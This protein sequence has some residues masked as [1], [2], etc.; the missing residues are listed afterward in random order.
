MALS[1]LPGGQG[2]RAPGP[3]LPQQALCS[4]TA[5]STGSCLGQGPSVIPLSGEGLGL[6][7]GPR[8]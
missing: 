1:S 5:T 3:P 4:F 6:W 2:S 8:R 7:L